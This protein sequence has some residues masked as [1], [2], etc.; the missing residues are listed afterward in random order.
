MTLIQIFRKKQILVLATCI[1]ELPV[2]CKNKE[3]IKVKKKIIRTQFRYVAILM[4]MLMK[5][6][7]SSTRCYIKL[8]VS[9]EKQEGTLRFH[10]EWE[11]DSYPEVID[12]DTFRDFTY[13][14]IYGFDVEVVLNN[15]EYVVI[16]QAQDESTQSAE[17]VLMFL[18]DIYT[19]AA[20]NA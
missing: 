15:H 5:R 13:E 17:K 6:E 18:Y 20:K 14:S 19:N 9:P 10:E 8:P 16:L 12:E 11:A 7:L 4:N 2:S 1:F 3:K